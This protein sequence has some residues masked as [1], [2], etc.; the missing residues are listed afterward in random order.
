MQT[1][2]R[3]FLALNGLLLA[4]YGAWCLLNPLVLQ[5]YAGFV[6]ETPSA[7]T[8]VRAM[9]GGLQLTVGLLFL[10]C[11]FQTSVLRLGLVVSAVVFL[12]LAPARLAG[13]ALLGADDYNLSAVIYEGICLALSLWLL[14][15]LRFVTNK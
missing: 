12:G 4:G 10:W 5:D 1:F 8:E 13:I 15:R 9:Y 2:A 6:L 14:G 11:G 7:I 3:V